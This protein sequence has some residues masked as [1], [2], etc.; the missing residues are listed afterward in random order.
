MWE[1]TCDFFLAFETPER[2][3]KLKDTASSLLERSAHSMLAHGVHMLTVQLPCAKATAPCRSFLTQVHD[4]TPRAKRVTV[5]ATGS[6]TLNGAYLL[7]IS[8]LEVNAHRKVR[9]PN[10]P[11]QLSLSPR[12]LSMKGTNVRGR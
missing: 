2:D 7:S 4:R 11:S 9:E 10:T 12:G 5:G 8:V 1:G 3:T 6:V